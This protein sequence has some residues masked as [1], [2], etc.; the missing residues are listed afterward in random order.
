MFCWSTIIVTIII[1]FGLFIGTELSGYNAE[2]LSKPVIRESCTCDCW[3]GFYRGVHPRGGYKAIYFNYE[4]Q[5]ILLFGILLFYAQLLRFYL[6]KIATARQLNLLLLI[7][8][9]YANYYGI[10]NIINYLNDHD[11]HRM[12]PSQTFFTTTELVASY[13]FYRCLLRQKSD[14][15]IEPWMIYI[16]T[17]ICS[18]HLL[19][20]VGELNV[21]RITRNILLIISDIIPLGWITFLMIRNA[22]LRPD[23][24][25]IFTYLGLGLGLWVFYHVIC[26][27]RD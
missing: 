11:Y 20:A 3:D 5:T 24:S 8:P 23:R 6:V 13:L 14:N 19:L 12:L 22:G 16:L 21:P 10:W 17:I 26:P 18:L 4:L 2:T 1:S 15:M 7:V 25:T 9:I 27:Y